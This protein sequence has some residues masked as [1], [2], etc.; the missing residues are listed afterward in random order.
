MGGVPQEIHRVNREAQLHSLVTYTLV[1]PLY[2][3]ATLSLRFF[4]RI[5]AGS[6][7]HVTHFPF[8]RTFRSPSRDNHHF[9]LCHVRTG[10]HE[11]A[12]EGKLHLL[13]D[14]NDGVLRGQLSDR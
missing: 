2:Q 11:S 13:R 4:E 7:Y 1:I 14:G 12:T 3:F 10:R 8:T 5:C 9:C 6:H